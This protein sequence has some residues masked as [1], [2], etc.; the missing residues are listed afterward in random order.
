MREGYRLNRDSAVWMERG[1][2]SAF[3]RGVKLS[4]VN[5]E[6]AFF[7]VAFPSPQ[8]F[9]TKK[10]AMGCTYTAYLIVRAAVAEMEPEKHWWVLYV[11]PGKQCYYAFPRR[12]TNAAK[13]KKASMTTPPKPFHTMLETQKKT[14]PF[15]SRACFRV[16]YQHRERDS[17]PLLCLHVIR[18]DGWYVHYGTY[19]PSK[20]G[21]PHSLNARLSHYTPPTSPPLKQ[22]LLPVNAPGPKTQQTR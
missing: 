15:F 18:R 10:L 2:P 22:V 8:G 20:N 6:N 17:N 4:H 21:W 3:F 7:C 5:V 14:S 16:V 19:H 13:K 11:Y 1:T 12:H 9:V